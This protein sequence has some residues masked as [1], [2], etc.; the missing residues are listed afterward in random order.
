MVDY[1]CILL[2]CNESPFNLLSVADNLTKHIL[3]SG[4][5]KSTGFSGAQITDRAYCRALKL[6]SYCKNIVL[7]KEFFPHAVAKRFIALGILQ[8]LATKINRHREVTYSLSP[9]VPIF[10]NEMTRKMNELFSGVFGDGTGH[11][12]VHS[13]LDP[14][15]LLGPNPFSKFY[16]C[17]IFGYLLGPFQHTSR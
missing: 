5:H 4:W 9:S 12:D 2:S 13:T 17:H 8:I 3:R 1:H 16:F 10:V 6:N 14:I 7:A 11:H 15:L